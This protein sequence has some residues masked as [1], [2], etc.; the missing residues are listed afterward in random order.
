M[1]WA[2]REYGFS[3]LDLPDGLTEIVPGAVFAT[4]FEAGCVAET[5]PDSRGSFFAR[6]S[7]G[8]SCLFSTVM[9]RGHRDYQ[10]LPGHL[11][12]L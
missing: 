7:D 11:Q 9:V 3:E 5:V 8:V 12:T 6:D 10:P 2:S 4:D 1:N